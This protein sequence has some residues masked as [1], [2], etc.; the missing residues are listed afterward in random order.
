MVAYLL[1]H[2][3]EKHKSMRE[4][5]DQ[6]RSLHGQDRL[7]VVQDWS[8]IEAGIF[9]SKRFPP[10]DFVRYLEQRAQTLQRQEREKEEDGDDDDDD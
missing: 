10:D 8:Q 2:Y 4:K 5:A 1:P 7:N 6:I 9:E 3:K